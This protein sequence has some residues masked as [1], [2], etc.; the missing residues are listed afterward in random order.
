M[1]LYLRNEKVHTCIHI[2]C[3]HA[4]KIYTFMYI[5]IHTCMHACMHAYLHICVNTYCIHIYIYEIAFSEQWYHVLPRLRLHM[6]ILKRVQ[7]SS[8]GTL[9][10][11]A[12][13]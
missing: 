5:Y 8:Q 2:N 12:E 1:Y 11:R 10:Q 3:I 4:F 7:G 13:T 9:H 6:T